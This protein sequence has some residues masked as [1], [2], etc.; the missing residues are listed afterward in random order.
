MKKGEMR[1]ISGRVIWIPFGIY[2]P[3]YRIL[4]EVS[5]RVKVDHGRATRL[6]ILILF[7]KMNSRGFNPWIPLSPQVTVTSGRVY[8]NPLPAQKRAQTPTVFPRQSVVQRFAN[9]LA[10]RRW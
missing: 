8:A 10:V 2:R 5:R 6:P 9:R 3:T 7:T 1:E 4:S